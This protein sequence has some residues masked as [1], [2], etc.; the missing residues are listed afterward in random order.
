MSAYQIGDAP[1]LVYR[2]IDPSTRQPVDGTVTCTVTPPTGSATTPTPAHPSTGTYQHAPTFT[3]EGLWT[4]RFASTGTV[5]DA[6]TIYL[7]V[8]STDAPPVWAPTL[9]DVAAHIPT[10]TRE[11][12]V[13]NDYL[14]T[15][16]ASTQPTADEVATLIGHAC[17]WVAGPAGDP[18]M[19]A[20]YSLLGAAAALRAAYW[21]EVAYPERDADVAVY[22]R[23][24]DDAEQMAKDAATANRAAGGGTSL[25]P[26]SGEPLALVQYTFPAAPAWADVTFI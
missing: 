16:T 21:V 3:V 19:T 5:V 2:L 7:F 17:A 14:G 24:K 9:A 23:L 4:V 26:S 1:L 12:G 11:V 13:D 25:D 8:G 10:R 22:D 6:E 20:A 15:F 18:V